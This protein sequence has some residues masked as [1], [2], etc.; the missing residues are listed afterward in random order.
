MATGRQLQKDGSSRSVL[1][2]TPV[3]AEGQEVNS[4]RL[5]FGNTSRST[6]QSTHEVCIIIIF[7]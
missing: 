2:A 3:V 7:L 1:G 5:L 6:S 4:R